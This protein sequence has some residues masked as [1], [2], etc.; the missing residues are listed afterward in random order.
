[1]CVTDQTTAKR[2]PHREDRH[3][4]AAQPNSRRAFH[5]A[6]GIFGEVLITVGVLI[7]GYILWQP[8][9]TSTVVANKQVHISDELSSEW[10]PSEAPSDG[11]AASTPSLEG[12]PVSPAGAD[13]QT[14]AVMHVP[15]FS[16]NF[17]NVIAETTD[18]PNV[19]NVSS[20]GVGHYEFTQ[21]LGE[22]G[23]FAIAGHRSGPLIN[24]FKEIM[25]LRV[26]DPI[27]IETKNGWY[28]YR[29]RSVEYVWPTEVDVLNPF[30]RLS[31]TTSADHILTLTTCH[32]KHD[33][34]AER[35]IAYAVLEDYSPLSEG[36]PAEL[37]KLNPNTKES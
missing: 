7:F 6:L 33:G 14:F 17:S 28:T 21:Q 11:A 12:M 36:V 26:G 23:N 10:R 22:P 31:M 30:P 35:A 2:E 18:L 1:M 25:N 16:P 19:L 27:F 13:Y 32:P 24:S 3:A 29:F 15:A 4:A 37:K 8:W 9:Y 34:D 20:K 5:T